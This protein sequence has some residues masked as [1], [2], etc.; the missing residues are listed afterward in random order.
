MVEFRHATHLH[1]NHCGATFRKEKAIIHVGGDHSNTGWEI[2]I[3]PHCKYD[4]ISYGYLCFICDEF[5]QENEY[6]P[7]LYLCK[8]CRERKESEERENEV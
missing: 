8:D 6:M 7:E 2:P 3:C 5:T 1:C 4:D